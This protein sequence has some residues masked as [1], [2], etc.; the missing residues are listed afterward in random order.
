VIPWSFESGST[1]L[2]IAIFVT[3][4]LGFGLFFALMKTPPRLRPKIA[5]TF[6]FLAGLLYVGI[7][8]WPTAHGREAGDIPANFTEGVAF[9][10]ED[11]Q[12]QFQNLSNILTSFLLLM[13]VFSLVR[14]HAT[15]VSKKQ[16]D[17][18]FSLVLLIC[19]AIMTF[20]GYWDWLTVM[21]MKPEELEAMRDVTNQ[22]FAVWM[23]DLLFDGLLQTMEAAM[24]S[25]IAFYILSAAYRAFR[26]R[27]VEATILLA[28]AIIVMLGLLGMAENY[29]SI[30]IDNMGGLEDPNALVNNLRLEA[31]TQ[32][33][34]DNLQTP[35]LRAIDF[36]VGV[37]ALAMALRLWLSLERGGSTS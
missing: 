37:G 19:V 18:P 6:T 15:R 28:S 8:L 3:L 33:I 27:S 1:Q 36:G 21:N 25:I 26:V 22:P 34:R 35:G 11:T 14:L 32:F 12:S 9:W 5:A 10:L 2:K 4:A 13:G 7:W 29:W 24:F 23:K 16:R 30:M 31:I 17:W 20:I